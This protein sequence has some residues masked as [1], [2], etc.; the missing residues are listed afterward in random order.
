[1]NGKH[2]FLF[3]AIKVGSHA[4]TVLHDIFPLFV[5]GEVCDVAA[6]AN[7]TDHNREPDLKVQILNRSGAFQQGEF[8]VP[9]GLTFR[10]KDASVNYRAF[11]PELVVG[12]LAGR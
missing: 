9:V 12:W 4:F 2:E 3:E 5:I 1:M 11:V 8:Y 6:D 7:I 10:R